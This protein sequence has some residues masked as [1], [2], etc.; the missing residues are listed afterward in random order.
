M[1]NTLIPKRIVGGGKTVDSDVDDNVTLIVEW[2]TGQ[3]AVV[4]TQGGAQVLVVKAD[5]KVEARTVRIGEVVD[6]QYVVED[7]LREGERVV[8]EGRDRAR[9][10]ETVKTKPWRAAATPAP[11]AAA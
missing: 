5:G 9:P 10:D 4:R 6:N 1:V 8:V 7:G 3:Q 2:E 11:A